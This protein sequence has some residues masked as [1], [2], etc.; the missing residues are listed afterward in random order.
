M[1]KPLVSI[2]IPVF[3]RADIICN[4][5]D[6]ILRQTYTNTEIVVVDDGSTDKISEVIGDYI[7][8]YGKDKVIY[9]YQDN[10]GPSFARNR[11]LHEC[12]GELVCFFDSDDIMMPERIEKQ[13][14][15]MIKQHSDLCLAGIHYM[16]RDKDIIPSLVIDSEFVHSFILNKNDVFM[17]TQGWLFKR[18]ILLKIKGYDEKLRNYEDCDLVFRYIASQDNLKV[19]IIPSVLTLY[20]DDNRNDRLTNIKNSANEHFQNG[21][22]TFYS[23]VIEYSIAKSIGDSII[24][25]Y[26]LFLKFKAKYYTCLSFTSKMKMKS[27][28]MLIASYSKNIYVKYYFYYLILR[29]LYVLKNGKK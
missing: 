4:T 19:S 24:Y 8:R 23:R 20:N 7:K 17:G 1:D 15:E 26:K 16:N 13:T 14:L 3:N 27:I 18:N 9:I 28:G 10:A 11:G 22:I 6:S 2:I 12:H 29:I 5:L 21:F 25:N